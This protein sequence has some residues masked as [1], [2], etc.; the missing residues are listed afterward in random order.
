MQLLNINVS[1]GSVVTHSRCG[2]IFISYFIANLQLSVP[3][4]GE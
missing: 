3:V 4:K 1:Q 2:E